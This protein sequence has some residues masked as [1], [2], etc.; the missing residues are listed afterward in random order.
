MRVS[1]G[2]AKRRLTLCL[3]IALVSALGGFGCGGEKES[4]SPGDTG[5][6]VAPEGRPATEQRA[7]SMLLELSDLPSGWRGASKKQAGGSDVDA[8]E[9]CLGVDFSQFDLV[10]DANSDNFKKRAAEVSSAA[11]IL[12]TETEARE[13]AELYATALSSEAPGCIRD[14][15]SQT[16]VGTAKSP[17]LEFQVNVTV[18][19]LKVGRPTGVSKAS[20]VRFEVRMM[21]DDASRSLFLEAYVSQE[22]DAVSEILTSSQSIPFDAQL[23]DHLIQ[24]VADRM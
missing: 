4:E 23:L 10:T 12:D 13:G 7:A 14:V 20:G 18:R 22:G 1:N 11:N 5:R 9:Q 21:V 2:T 16:L 6:I 17:P 15:A 24:T 8:F 19:P 3:G